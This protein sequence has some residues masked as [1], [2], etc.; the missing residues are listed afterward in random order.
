[1]Y[2]WVEIGAEEEGVPTRQV[3]GD[4]KDLVELAYQAAHSSRFNIGVGISKEAVVLHEQHMP[5][6]QPVLVFKYS[7]NAP[8]LCRLMGANAA[9]MV[10]H[11]PL[12]IDT[13]LSLPFA[14]RKPAVVISQQTKQHNPPSGELNIDSTQLVRLI[15]AIVHKLHE[16]GM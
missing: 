11:R 15:V 3:S 2:R 1:L 4:A 13:D 12:H 8:Y 7:G 16:R 5:S 9:R 10:V 6:E 14:D